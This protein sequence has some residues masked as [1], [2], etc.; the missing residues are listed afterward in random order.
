MRDER[1]PNTAILLAAGRGKRLMPYTNNTPKPL[2]QFKNRPIFDY[3]LD[4]LKFA[5]IEN[6]CV[7]TNY[8]EDEIISHVTKKYQQQ[9]NITFCH[10]NNLFGSANA[11][12][13]TTEYIKRD[14]FSERPL[15]ISAT[16]YIMPID[17]VRDLIQYHINNTS[18]IT[19][20]LRKV[21]K[22]KIMNSSLA[23]KNDNGDL[24]KIIE[25]PENNDK[26]PLLAASLLY[27]VPPNIFDYLN[28]TT[29]SK[30][31]EYELPD[32]VNMMINDGICAK[33]LLQSKLID[34]EGI[35]TT[36]V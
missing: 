15:I 28:E 23:I 13:S 8:L 7:V 35:V 33:G 17:Y 21:S 27:V 11:V 9:F 12:L 26:E 29:L 4:A 10:Q 5:N 1:I 2:L 32:V 6:I 34:L 24:I 22:D 18:E 19:I 25:K 3:V 14:I 31:G 30:R 20:S 36:N 16:D